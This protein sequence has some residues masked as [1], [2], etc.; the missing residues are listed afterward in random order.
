MQDIY[1][2]FSSFTLR[3]A[4]TCTHSVPIFF[5][6]SLV[7]KD[8]ALTCLEILKCNSYELT[9]DELRSI[10]ISQGSTDKTLLYQRFT[11]KTLIYQGSTVTINMF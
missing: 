4:D 3:F 8:A 11:A 9:N 10:S 2:A 5:Y 1:V 6:Y 7:L